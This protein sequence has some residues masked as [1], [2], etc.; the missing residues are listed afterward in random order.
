MREVPPTSHR[1]SARITRSPPTN[2]GNT[3]AGY[4]AGFFLRGHARA[5]AGEDTS[6]LQAGTTLKWSQSYLYDGAGRITQVT[7]PHCVTGCSVAERSVPA[8]TVS[9]RTLPR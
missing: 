9:S 6:L 4:H 7:Y 3:G 1:P 5:A 8:A 2:L